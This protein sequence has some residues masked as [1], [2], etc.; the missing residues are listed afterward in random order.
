MTHTDT[1]II[2]KIFASASRSLGYSYIA[3]SKEKAG[4]YRTVKLAKSHKRTYFT[5]YAK[6]G[7]FYCIFEEERCHTLRM[8]NQDKVKSKQMQSYERCIKEKKREEGHIGINL[9]QVQ[10][11]Q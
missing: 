5:K 4:I 8:L 7:R 11:M 1:Q 9:N 6:A 2:A 10:N 3:S